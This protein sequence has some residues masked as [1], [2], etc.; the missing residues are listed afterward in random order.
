MIGAKYHSIAEELT[1]TKDTLQWILYVTKNIERRWFRGW[2]WC[3]CKYAG[4]ING[5]EISDVV[6]GAHLITMLTD[7]MQ[8]ETYVYE[9]SWQQEM[10]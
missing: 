3:F 9:I 5:D 6:I 10:I 7:W 4:D 2:I 8:E 1:S